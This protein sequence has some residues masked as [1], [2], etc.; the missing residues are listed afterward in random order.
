MYWTTTVN[1]PQVI[2]GK[3]HFAGPAY[4]P[5]IFEVT[6]LL[7]AV[8]TALTMLFVMF[9]LPN[10]SYPLQDTKYMKSVSVD[11]FGAVIEANDP[12]FD[13][14]KT[15]RLLLDLGAHDV[16]LIYH[17]E[18]EFG[19][20]PVVFAPRFIVFLVIAAVLTS[21]A[22]YFTLNKLMFMSPFSWM[23]EQPKIIPQDNDP[24]FSDGFS[25]RKPVEG[26][27][28]RGYMP[29]QYA[30]NPDLAGEALKN[31]LPPTT[32]NLAMGKKK[33]DTFCSPCHGYL[34]KGDARL[35]GNFPN[36]PSLHSEKVRNWPDGRIYYVITEGQNIMPSYAQQTTRDERWA[37]ILY[38][39]TLERALNA[40]EGDVQ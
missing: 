13:E 23:M 5:I 33:F 30:D 39:R 19:I 35:N 18:K 15:K 29:F 20:K 3:P 17:D 24:F 25:V 34:A 26:T 11:K 1:Y 12:L 36:P 21:G 6:V 2:G 22:T 8:G 27:V 32:A 14:E 31:P 10:N 38:I 40:K 37:I 9:K 28:A 16:E 7:A 4:V